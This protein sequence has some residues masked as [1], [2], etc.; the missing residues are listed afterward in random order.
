MLDQLQAF[1]ES[2]HP[3]LQWLGVA[4]AGAIPFI[5]SY[6]GSVLGVAAGLNPVVAILAASLGNA[7]TM[8]LAVYLAGAARARLVNEQAEESPRRRRLRERFDRW[9]VPG[10]SLLGQTLLP[11]QITSAA[12]VSFGASRRQ[13]ILWQAISI[14]LWGT[15]FGVLAY[16]G[17]DILLR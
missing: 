2:L 9:G 16:L 17:I 13:V 15:A 4:A 5:E 8:V 12:L 7:A 14:L 11:S 6:F 10:V 3:L 1:T